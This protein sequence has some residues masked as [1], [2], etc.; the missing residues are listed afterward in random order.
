[1]QLAGWVLC[2]VGLWVHIFRES[3]L[4]GVLLEDNATAPLLVIDR[5]PITFIACGTV[6]VVI[7]FLGFVSTLST[8]HHRRH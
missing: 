7:G 5:V 4:I 8:L 2:G 3:L 1:M 6:I